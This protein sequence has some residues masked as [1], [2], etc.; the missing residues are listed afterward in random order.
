MECTHTCDLSFLSYSLIVGNFWMKMWTWL[1]QDFFDGKIFNVDMREIT[2]RGIWKDIRKVWNSR[3]GL[4]ETEPGRETNVNKRR[5]AKRT[6]FFLQKTQQ[7]LERVR[8]RYCA[9]NQ[10]TEAADP[11]GWIREKEKEAEDEC[12]P[13]GGQAVS[14]NLELWDLSNSGPPTRQQTQADMRPPTHTAEDCWVCVQSE[15]MNFTL[16]RL[17]APESL[18]VRWAG[19]W[20]VGIS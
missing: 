2:A 17:E 16:K 5:E 7:A 10:W 15:M 8:S 20:W 18:E 13:V 4:V 19:R 1:L 9:P 14:I 3:H 11:C 6:K 12:G